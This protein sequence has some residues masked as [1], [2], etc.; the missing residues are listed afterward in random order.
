MKVRFFVTGHGRSGT[1]WL[2]R[3]LNT[4]PNMQVHHEPIQEDA[5]AYLQIVKGSLDPHEYLAH[6]RKLMMR[7]WASNPERDWAEVNSYLRYCVPALREE[8]GAPVV[9]LVRDGRLVVRSMMAR[10]VFQREGYPGIETPS[11]FKTPFEKCCW[12]WADTY[13]RLVRTGVP[14]FKLEDLNNDYSKLGLLCELLGVRVSK[15]AWKSFK[16]R[17]LNVDVGTQPLNWSKRELIT[18]QTIAGDIQT[19][20]GYA[21]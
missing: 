18:F 6:R 17:P 2:A 15:S 7:I 20:F 14:T 11:E 13:W 1:M 21:I 9:G 10:G 12:Y 8:F 4:D 19:N 3:L 16:N 5:S